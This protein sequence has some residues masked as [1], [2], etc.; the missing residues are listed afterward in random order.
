MVNWWSRTCFLAG[1]TSKH[2]WRNMRSIPCP[3]LSCKRVSL[4]AVTIARSLTLSSQG[5]DDVLQFEG[6]RVSYSCFGRVTLLNK[7][8]LK[9]IVVE[10]VGSVCALFVADVHWI[11]CSGY[12]HR[13]QWRISYSGIAP[14][15]GVSASCSNSNHW[16][17]FYRFV[18]LI[19]GDFVRV[20]PTSYAVTP[21][22][23]DVTNKDFVLF[24]KFPK[25]FTNVPT[26]FLK[27]Q[28]WYYWPRGCSFQR[29]PQECLRAIASRF[30]LSCASC[31]IVRF[32]TDRR[33]EFHVY[34]IFPLFECC[35]WSELHCFD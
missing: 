23:Q 6:L 26:F 3:T 1:T 21:G 34:R 29:R 10:A 18:C 15:A 35:C 20:Q 14:A 28:I 7:Q 13:C 8:P 33:D 27:A 4:S 25:Y 22:N 16:Y 17:S 11:D 9:S 32:W 12:N 30:V 5:E 2:C 24:K 19:L 31:L